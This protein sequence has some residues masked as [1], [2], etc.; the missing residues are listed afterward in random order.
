M[1]SSLTAGRVKEVMA[2][3]PLMMLAACKPPVTDEPGMR[4]DGTAPPPQINIAD[5]PDTALAVWA[6]SKD[7]GRIIYGIPGSPALFTLTCAP[8]DQAGPMLVFDRIAMA[9]ANAK[10]VLSLIGNDEAARMP[11][12]AVQDEGAWIWRGSVAAESPAWEALTGPEPAEATV[13]GAGTLV[14]N[15]SVLPGELI[16]DCLGPQAGPPQSDP[17]S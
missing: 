4:A 13:P 3:V 10:A 17:V 12:D 14:L 8:D 5:A 1:A 15:P 6:K 11:I 7:A 2:L 9:D 16:A